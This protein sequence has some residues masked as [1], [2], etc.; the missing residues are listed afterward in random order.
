MATASPP[1]MADFDR[2]PSFHSYFLSSSKNGRFRQVSFLS[3]LFSFFLQEWPISTG[4]L[5]FLLIFFLPPRMAD[6]DRYPS[7]HSYFLSSSKNG[8]FRQVSFLSFLF[9]FFL[10]EWPI[11]TGI[12]PF[13]LI[14]FLPPRMAD[15]DRYPSFPSY[16][17]SSFL[18]NFLSFLFETLH[19][20]TL[21]MLRHF[22]V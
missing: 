12:L 1:R 16:F 8:R 19:I 11:S 21:Y 2:Y 14:F 9:S 10:Q 5:P 17:L 7:F 6:F 13:I 3:F 20:E 22:T 4:I 15:F 18:P